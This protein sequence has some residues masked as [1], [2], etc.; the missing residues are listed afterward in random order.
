[1]WN[2]HGD[3]GWMGDTLG[4]KFNFYYMVDSMVTDGIIDATQTKIPDDIMDKLQTWYVQHIHDKVTD[5]GVPN[6]SIA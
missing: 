3:Y 1:M 5:A 2:A 6:S 4:G